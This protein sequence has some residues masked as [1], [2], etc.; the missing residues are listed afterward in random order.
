MGNVRGLRRATV[1]F[2]LSGATGLAYEV[3][4]FRRFSHIWG[5]STLAMAAVVSSFLLGLGIGASLLGRMADQSPSPLRGY[6]WCEAGIGLLALLIPYECSLL[7]AATGALYPALHSLPLLYTL[8]RF[9]LTFLVLGPPC[10]LMGGTFP[11]LVRQFAGAGDLGPT[12]GWLYAV[13]TGGAAIGCY[14]AGFHLLPWLGLSGSNFLAAGLNMSIALAAVL[15]AGRLD[16]IAAPAAASSPASASGSGPRL[17]ALYAAAALTGL[18]A[19]LLQMVWT[20][21]LCVMLGGSTYALTSTL[22]VILLGIGIGSLIFRTVVSRL[23]DPARAAAGS[24][25]LLVLSAGATKLLVHPLTMAV[26]LSKDLRSLGLG[27]AAVCI[28]AS[29]VLE[30]LPSVCMGFNFPLLV[31]LTRRGAADAGRAVGSVYAWNTAGSIFGAAATAPVGLALLGGARTMG[32]GLAFYLIAGAL[33][34]PLRGRRNLLSV[35]AFAL[36]SLAGIVLGT[37]PL[38]PRI[39]EQGMYLYGYREWEHRG[40]IYYKEGAACNVCV[41]EHLSD[42][43]LAVNGKVDATSEGD[44]DMQLGI[45]YLPRFLRPEA[46]NVLVIG[47]GSGTTSGASLLFP[48]TRVTCCEIEPAVYGA[49][50]EF[51]R[52]NHTPDRSPNFR[53]LFDDGR[54]H[55]QGTRDTYDL[56]LSEP[57]N[58]WLAGVASLFTREFYALCREKLGGRG[59]LGQWIQLYSFSDAEYA[60]VIR[61]ATESFRYACLLRISSSD[62]VLLCSDAPIL[63]DRATVDAS[64]RLLDALPDV[65][66]DLKKHLDA[67][68]VRSALLGRLL[69][70]EAGLRRLAERRPSATVNTD[71]NLRLEFDAPL[72]LFNSDLNPEV[73]MDPIIVGAVRSEWLRAMIQGW[74]C[75]RAQTPALR[76]LAALLSKH[77]LREIAADVLDLALAVDPGHPSLLAERVIAGSDRSEEELLKIVAALAGPS[78]DDALKIG[79]E[80]YRKSKYPLAVKV[81]TSILEAHPESATTWQNLGSTYELMKDAEKAGAAYEKACRLDPL[82]ASAR[83]ERDEFRKKQAEKKP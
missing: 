14:L 56:I 2:F 73:D 47:Y 68:D 69:L 51:S 18:G 60:L 32:A 57:S 75:T 37:R 39:T 48:G 65:R 9:L 82:N 10:I 35:G 62:T 40:V 13:N 55:L 49:S 28:A 4:W 21:Q 74:G 54:S 8:V 24:L 15:L 46:K 61:T 42:R 3:I 11:L 66:A 22:F 45:A 6:A 29:A 76:A 58:P 71:L 12:A 64:Q 25:A 7:S 16:P 79:Q 20:R 33:L 53:I 41:T 1:L 52:V 83:K 59:V 72:R 67:D 27:N 81:Y 17:G 31:H 26:G 38:D 80:L 78:P 63:P 19:L 30:F 44:M 43:A 36:V 5:A 23:A 50:G 34:A 77:Q 70:D